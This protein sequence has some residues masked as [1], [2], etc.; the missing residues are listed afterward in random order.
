MSKWK[1]LIPRPKSNFAQ[2]KCASCGNEQIIFLSPATP[3]TCNVCSAI[4][5]VSRG[6]KAE[7]KGEIISILE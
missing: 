7:I 4:L 5:A 1:N 2:V 6:G 3:V